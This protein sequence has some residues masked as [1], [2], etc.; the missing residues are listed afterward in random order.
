M[1]TPKEWTDLIAKKQVTEAMIGQVLFSIN[2]R[3]KNYRDQQ[4][5]IKPVGLLTPLAISSITKKKK[6]AFIK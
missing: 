4:K 1:K 2:K 6:P 3:A 5:N